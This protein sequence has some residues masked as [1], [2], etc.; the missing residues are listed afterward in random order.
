MLILC[1]NGH[2]YQT[3]IQVSPDYEAENREIFR[4]ECVRVRFIYNGEAVDEYWLS[5]RCAAEENVQAGD[6]PLPDEYPTWV[7]KVKAVC[8]RCFEQ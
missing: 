2:G 8:G 4:A 3:P 1:P 7:G 6:Q 5:S